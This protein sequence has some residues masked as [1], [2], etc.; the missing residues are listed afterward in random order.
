MFRR[1]RDS[2]GQLF[3]LFA[4]TRSRRFRQR[5]RAIVRQKGRRLLA[6]GLEP[7]NLMAA[8]MLGVVRGTTWL[9]DTVPGPAHEIDRAYGLGGDR[10]VA[11]RWTGTTDMMGAVRP[12][13]DGLLH[14]L[15]DTNGDTTHDIEVRFGFPTD[16]PVVGDW[17]GDG[18][19][20][21]GV[22]RAMPDGLLH[23]LLDTNGDPTAEIDFAFGLPGDVPVVGD[24]DHNGSD[25]AGVARSGSAL[26]QWYFD[27][28]RDPSDEMRAAFGMTSTDRPIVGDW[29]GDGFVN[30]GVTRPGAD[31]LL[32]WLRDSNGDP[33]AESEVAYG[34]STD[35]PVVGKWQYAEMEV[36]GAPSNG[37]E[38]NIGSAPQGAA[39]G[40]TH[41][42]TVRN[43]GNAWLGIGQVH[44][45]P[46]IIIVDPP[47]IA[48][49][50]GQTDT[51]TVR[52]ADTTT[53]GLRSGRIWID[54]ADG[55]EHPYVIQITGQVVEGN[56]P[57]PEPRQDYRPLKGSGINLSI[58]RGLLYQPGQDKK[59]LVTVAVHVENPNRAVGDYM[60]SLWWTN[61]LKN[62]KK[63]A[64]GTIIAS[65]PRN[66]PQGTQSVWFPVGTATL[67]PK[68]MSYLVAIV[69]P[70]S[71]VPE[72]SYLDNG[73]YLDVATKQSYSLP[74]NGIT[75]PARTFV[76]LLSGFG[77]SGDASGV[78][79]LGAKIQQSGLVNEVKVFPSYLTGQSMLRD[80]QVFVDR[81]L[82][83]AG[84]T[85]SDRVI[86]IGHSY[87][88][89]AARRLAAD[90]RLNVKGKQPATALVTIDPI[91]YE[92]VAK[93]TDQS[94][95]EWNQ[96][97]PGGMSSKNVLNIIQRAGSIRGYN[98]SG[99]KTLTGKN[100][101]HTTVDDDKQTHQWV[102]DFLRGLPTKR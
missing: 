18:R 87:G 32:H 93:G 51:L 24:W 48:L 84:V 43:P 68:G 13:T 66:F 47:T 88:G 79:N 11:G 35:T 23:W 65:V 76:Y 45:D 52:F 98:I 36:L 80:A 46:G 17:D 63:I 54:N 81:Q 31:G 61:D 73:M 53:P 40:P 94:S 1:I 50:P 5:R 100:V 101:T 67:Q 75:P 22:V 97:I 90:I 60:V 21:V 19:E 83:A 38:I 26:F 70:T 25:N 74:N 10:F 20:N 71:D 4:S 8:D 2:L 86:I 102:L 77:L 7:R 27:T 92:K 49:P 30:M 16:T 41:T 15:L 6:E 12:G 78:A 58:E 69:N 62:P 33:W 44:A 14:W 57:L 96:K 85:P 3:N 56:P 29:D 34:F 9:F 37:S 28:N 89:D 59:K 91:D 55:G 72:T 64:A 95:S 99:A 39:Q 82:S 42:F